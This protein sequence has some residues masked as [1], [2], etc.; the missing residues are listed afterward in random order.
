[1]IAPDV[2]GEH[3]ARH[4]LAGMAHEELEDAELARRQL[5]RLA[6]AA[7]PV[8][9]PRRARDRPPAGCE[10]PCPGPR[11]SKARMRATSSAERERLAEIIVGAGVQPGD[12]I[13]HRA[14][15]REDQHRTSSSGARAAAAAARRRPPRA[16]RGRARSD[17][18]G[19]IRMRR[20]ASSTMAQRSTVQLASSRPACRWRAS[21][22]SSSTTSRRI[23]DLR[24]RIGAGRASSRNSSGTPMS[25]KSIDSDS[26][27]MMAIASGCC[28]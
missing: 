17:R 5:D 4:H 25:E 10:T 19:S 22:C 24:A 15:R 23:G 20:Q 12:A 13:V 27:P 6:A 7:A 2:L 11:R 18:T 21:A 26:P 16:D 14:A 9:A 1:M 28:I 3:G 8:A